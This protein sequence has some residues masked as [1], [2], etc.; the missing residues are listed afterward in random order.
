MPQHQ[1]RLAKHGLLV[2]LAGNK[3]RVTPADKITPELRDYIAANKAEIQAELLQGSRSASAAR[4]VL[5]S[6][7]SELVQDA[8][9]WY[10]DDLDVIACMDRRGLM[11]MVLDYL[12]KKDC[13]ER[14]VFDA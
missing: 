2:S 3:L 7:I 11:R 8:M 4:V 13:Y 12:S 5:E 10:R 14:R 1:K 9:A 6:V